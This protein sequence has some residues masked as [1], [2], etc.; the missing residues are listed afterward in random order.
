MLNDKSVIGLCG[1]WLIFIS[2]A[3][4]QRTQRF[5]QLILS[6]CQD[7]AFEELEVFFGG[8]LEVGLVTIA[9]VETI[10]HVLHEGGGMWFDLINEVFV[11]GFL[12]EVKD[13]TIVEG[14]WTGNLDELVTVNPFV[15]FLCAISVFITS[16]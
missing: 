16:S 12:V 4:S 11:L 8:Y 13:E 6:V 2:L 14:V 15:A 1:L 5:Q 3:K 7:V 10:T 9:E